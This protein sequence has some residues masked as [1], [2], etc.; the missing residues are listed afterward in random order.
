MLTLIADSGSTKTDW[1][2]VEVR[3]GQPRV[4]HTVQTTGLNPLYVTPDDII[5]TLRRVLD[6]VGEGRP[7][8]LCFYGSGFSGSRVADVERALRG[9]LTPMTRVEV[10]SDLLAAARALTQPGERTPFV[11]CIV[12]T[13]AIAA[14]YDPA[15]GR[16]TPMPAL[17]YILGD[18]GSGAWLGRRLLGDY[19]KGQMP[20]RVAEAFEAD[21]GVI[22]P[23]EAIRRTYRAD[24]PNRYLATFA[25]FVGRG[26]NGEGQSPAVT[27]YLEALAF[28][29]IEAFWTRN[30]MRIEAQ[31]LSSTRDVRLV[32]SVAYGLSN[33]VRQVAFLHGYEVTKIE[34]SPL[35]GL[36][37]A[38]CCE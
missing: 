36:I 13:G 30:V 3:P 25:A 19:L 16:L 15:I 27:R 35:Q 14:L 29:G 32:G 11:A 7:D 18:E 6:Q 17:G 1:A 23:E 10:A 20:G 28:E 31:G 21:F 37:A 24:R 5:A 9:A 12:G 33:Q 4:V 26:L 2:L 34:P 38:L 8:R 22:T